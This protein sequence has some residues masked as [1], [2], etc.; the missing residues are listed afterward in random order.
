LRLRITRI[1]DKIRFICDPEH[2][3]KMLKVIDHNGGRVEERRTNE[4]GVFFTVTKKQDVD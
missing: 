1:G 3:E 4:E 2:V